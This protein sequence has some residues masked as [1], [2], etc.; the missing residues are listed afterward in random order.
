MGTRRN[1]LTAPG[2]LDDYLDACVQL[3]QT[4][5]GL[6]ALDVHDWGRQNIP[7]WRMAGD[8]SAPI[9]WWDYFVVMHWV[10]MSLP[11]AGSM[12][13]RAHGGPIFLP[14]HRM[15]LRRL[16]EIIQQLT[17]DPDFALPY[18]DWAADRTLSSPLWA[19]TRLGRNRGVVTNG[20]HGALRVTLRGRGSL[21]LGGFLLA[22]QPRPIDR[23][24]GRSGVRLPTKA[25]VSGCLTETE[26]DEFSWDANAAAGHRN[27]L[28]GWEDGP[29]LH[30]SVHVWVGGDMGPGTSPNDPV[31]YLNHCNA[32][33]IWEAWMQRAAGRV[34]RP[35]GTPGEN[36]PGHNLGDEMVTLVGQPM[37]PAQTLDM[38]ADYDYDT[39]MV[40]V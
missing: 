20:R 30:N 18:W 7:N 34:Y 26:Y 19:N 27:R 13:N 36:V 3:S 35:D 33:R 12:S 38:T 37:T 14:W 4:P 39:L 2:D 24:A 17:G 16:E 25:D 40:E 29:Q 21:Q 28:E 8:G 6:T 1:A 10:A 15:Y 5:T 9:S 22:E 32:D 23:N 31:F 11:T